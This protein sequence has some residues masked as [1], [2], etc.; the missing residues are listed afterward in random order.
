MDTPNI[1]TD[2]LSQFAIYGDFQGLAPLGNGHINSTFVSSWNQGGTLVRYT[3]QKI[4]D[5]V[6]LHP[7]E[8]MENIL[9]VTRHIAEKYRHEKNSSVR[10]LTV[11]PTKD[12]KPFARDREGGWWRTYLFIEGVHSLETAQTPS[13]LRFLGAAVG[14]FQKQLSDIPGKRLNETIPNFHNMKTRYQRFYEALRN[15]VCSRAKEAA[16]EITFMEKNEERGGILIN[17]LAD[18]SIPER[19]CHNDAKMNNILISDTDEKVFCVVD[20]DTVMPGSSLFDLGDLI[21]SGTNQAAED[22]Q[23]LSKVAFNFN[24]FKALLEGYLSE[25]SV[26]LNPK[27]KTLL[28]EAG[29]NITQIMALR[30]L[31]DYLE[32]DHYYHID[33]PGHNID[34]CR[35]Q[36][37]LIESMDAMWEKICAFS[38]GLV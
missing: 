1:F 7:D 4:N 22:E 27:E 32:G 38:E 8:V 18:G 30:F 29:R 3:H 20:L 33:R 15:D 25:A 12:G 36:I 11:V 6:F 14:R 10:T 37:A 35:S 21:R 19:I 16:A 23:D 24:F 13:E 28:A 2:V 17:A 26:F 5:Q 34:R 9:R 31:T